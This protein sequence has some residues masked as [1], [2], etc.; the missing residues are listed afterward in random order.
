MTDPLFLL[1]GIADPF[2]TVGARVTLAGDEGRHAAVVRRIQPGE[3][4]MIG[5]GRG[6]GVRGVVVEVRGSGLVVEVLSQLTTAA[7]PRCF[8]AAQ[9]LVKG[10]RSEL[11]V[12]MMTEMGISEIVPWQAARSIVHW[13]PDL[14][15]Q[16]VWLEELRLSGWIPEYPWEP[17]PVIVNERTVWPYERTQVVS[18]EDLHYD[19]VY[20][21]RENGA[22]MRER[23]EPTV[24]R[25]EGI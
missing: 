11:A 8:V 7:E 1:D 3:M 12:E 23:L 22:E 2:P 16:D 5:N 6:R 17:T 18:A 10:D 20:G 13:T 15:N 9:A 4:I 19:V 21:S 25:S 24:P 14:G